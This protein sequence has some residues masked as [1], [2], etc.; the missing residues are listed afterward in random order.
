MFQCSL[1]GHA[2][3]LLL[4]ATGLSNCQETF[5]P[6]GTSF[7]TIVYYQLYISLYNRLALLPSI[8]AM[9]FCLLTPF[10]GVNTEA[11]GLYAII[12]DGL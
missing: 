5:R 6:T 11:I 8:D 10:T 7:G 12:F 1:N 4:L 9:Q 2:Q 3:V